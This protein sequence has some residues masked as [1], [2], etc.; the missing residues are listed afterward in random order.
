MLDETVKKISS[1]VKESE[2]LS[3]AQKDELLDL[4][5]QLREELAALDVEHAEQ[6]K[7]IAGFTEL[8]TFEYLRTERNPELVAYAEKELSEALEDYEASHPSLYE[9]VQSICFML[10]GFGV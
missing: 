3:E 9:T 2:H 10:R 5:V 4:A 1:L 8:T 7:R 6:V